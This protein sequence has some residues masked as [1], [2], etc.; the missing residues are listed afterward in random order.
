MQSTL[1]YFKLDRLTAL[2]TGHY[3]NEGRISR[4]IGTNY[5]N[6]FSQSHRHE[7]G[8]GFKEA[9]LKLIVRRGVPMFTQRIYVIQKKAIPVPH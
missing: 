5:C 8:F 9:G 3:C 2:S 4:P 7:A 6:K 1:D